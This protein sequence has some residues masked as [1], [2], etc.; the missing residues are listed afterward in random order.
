MLQESIF[1]LS[2]YIYIDRDVDIDINKLYFNTTETSKERLK[3]NNK[4]KILL[5]VFVSGHDPRICSA[6]MLVFTCLM[7]KLDSCFLSNFVQD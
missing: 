7:F 3:D 2:R 5:H 6:H 4:S 1:L